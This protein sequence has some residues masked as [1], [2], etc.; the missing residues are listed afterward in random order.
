MINGGVFLNC[1]FLLLLSAVYHSIWRCILSETIYLTDIFLLQ[2]VIDLLS[3]PVCF[4]IMVI[5]NNY[6]FRLITDE[7]C[8]T[9]KYF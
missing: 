4:I 7:A 3:L 9:V 5:M 6:E 1:V 8:H 2:G